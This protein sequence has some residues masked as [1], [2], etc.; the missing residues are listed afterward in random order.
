[1]YDTTYTTI[2]FEFKHRR[3]DLVSKIVTL[4]SSHPSLKLTY[5]FVIVIKTMTSENIILLALLPVVTW[6]NILLPNA[7]M[8]KIKPHKRTNPNIFRI[9]TSLYTFAIYILKINHNYI[10]RQ[11]FLY[12]VGNTPSIFVCSSIET[13]LPSM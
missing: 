13:T 12:Q 8:A 10:T 1:M 11:L 3:I 2:N 9:Q 6:L 5:T 7:S 4:P